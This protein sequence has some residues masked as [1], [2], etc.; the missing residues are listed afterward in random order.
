MREERPEDLA[1][2]SAQLG[3]L[4]SRLLVP[5]AGRDRQELVVAHGNV[6]RWLVT[7][8]LGVDPESW[9]VMSIGHA[10]LTVLRI[11]PTGE[12]RLLALGDVGHLPPN[13][14]TGRV[15]DP[16][17]TLAVPAAPAAPN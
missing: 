8:V 7:R 15:G 5:A 13:L 1:A 10:S 9:L 6:I 12:A 16:E 11:E 4:A 3:R 17:R 2:C 14:Q